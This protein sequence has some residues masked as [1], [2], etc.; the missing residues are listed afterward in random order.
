MLGAIWLLPSPLPPLRH[1]PLTYLT[2][3]NYPTRPPR[4]LGS[5]LNKYTAFKCHE[6]AIRGI[7]VC[8]QRL[9]TIGGE[10]VRIGP[11][12]GVASTLI[13]PGLGELQ[14]LALQKAKGRGNCVLVG[15]EQTT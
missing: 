10:K 1:H 11:K 14:C 6:D 4:Y 8:N 12:Q 15:G 9:V 7:I 2:I 5:S 3:T 13:D